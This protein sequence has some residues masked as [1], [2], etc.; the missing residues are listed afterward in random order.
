MRTVFFAAAVALLLTGCNRPPSE[1]A[2]EKVVASLEDQWEFEKTKPP[3]QLEL[4]VGQAMTTIDRNEKRSS[5]LMR[6]AC[7]RFHR[8]H[9][10]KGEPVTMPVACQAASQVY[11]W[12]VPGHVL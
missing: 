6:E 2:V 8:N 3:A 7:T 9:T 4:D 12:K 10:L 1:R 5:A 11:G